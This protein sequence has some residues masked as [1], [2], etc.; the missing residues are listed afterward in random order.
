MLAT[1]F[2]LS[3]SCARIIKPTSGKVR[4]IFEV[5]FIIEMRHNRL[6][7]Q[8]LCSANAD[9]GNDIAREKTSQ[10]LRDAVAYVAPK[11]DDD[12][13]GKSERSS[14]NADRT[15]RRR[16]NESDDEREYSA[17]VRHP[18]YREVR[19]PDYPILSH[20][21]V[22]LPGQASCLSLDTTP[23]LLPV[24]P[25]S[26]TDARKRPRY[27][28]SPL[29][30]YQSTPNHYLNTP[31]H[32]LGVMLSP[33]PRN[34]VH[35][36]GVV[37]YPGVRTYSSNFYAVQS[38]RAYSTPQSHN[39]PASVGPT[40]ESVALDEPATTNQGDFDLFNGELLSDHSGRGDGAL[41]PIAYSGDF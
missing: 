34:Q 8:I 20:P 23:S 19:S 15:F 32:P 31:A 11:E 21:Y 14:A 3:D 27:Y 35:R 37:F 40:V 17:C 10:V 22:S 33:P 12:V 39:V 18:D 41:S 13:G 36:P 25:A 9:V 30:S 29:P 1:S 5:S 16:R 6:I 4:L 38:P 24:T 26:M 2:A 28:E 7:F